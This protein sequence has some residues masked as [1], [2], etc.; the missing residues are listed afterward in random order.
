MWFYALGFV[1]LNAFS[2]LFYREGNMWLSGFA[3]GLSMVFFL[4]ALEELSLR[5][6]KPPT[7]RP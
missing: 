3:T 4:L 1:G 2:V 5:S 6:Q 7:E